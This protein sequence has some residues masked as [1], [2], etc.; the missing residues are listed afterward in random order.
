MPRSE[1]D[2]AAP[3]LGAPNAQTLALVGGFVLAAA[4]TLAVFLTDDAQHL[5]VAVVAV[6][7]AFVL[8]M[9]AAGRRATD[10]VAAAAREAELHRVYEHE[11][12]REVAA[13]REYELELENDLR[14]EA[15]DSMRDEL[16]ALRGDL[17]AL[18]SLRDDVARVAALGD[19]VAQLSAL[20]HDL[21]QLGELRADM[22]RLRAEL[23]EQLSSELFIERIV[24]RTQAG[25]L[26]TDVGR[27][28]VSGHTTEGR[29]SE[30]T[31]TWRDD[32]PPRELT[33]GWPAV[34]LDEPRAT[35]QFEQVRVEQ[36]GVRP[37]V[38]MSGPVS[39]RS[40]DHEPD[41]RSWEIPATASWETLGTY[42]PST[43][44]FP[45]VGQ[46]PGT[47]H[48][49]DARDED[50]TPLGSSAQE[51]ATPIED[52]DRSRHSADAF[53]AHDLRPPPAAPPTA[54]F[55]M[56]APGA[57]RSAAPRL[58]PHK[59]PRPAAAPI[60]PSVVAPEPEPVPSPLEWLAAR[61]L[62][63]PPSVSAR[64]DVPPRR[65][66]DDDGPTDPAEVATTQRPAVPP[67]VRGDDRGGSRAAVGQEQPV[68][69]G[70]EQP[71]EPVEPP[72]QEKRLADILAENGISL[73][74]GGRRRRRYRA[75]DDAD[76]VLARVLRN[77]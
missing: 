59:R 58:T 47:T 52:G 4:A 7:W 69:V 68:A 32:V 71:V 65:R 74:A 27:G 15:G 20:R 31:V 14:R 77:N 35:W 50:A 1:D 56:A 62:L 51:S 57:G 73:G 49:S 67:P 12:A 64:P 26:S 34:R 29:I 39:W 21:G 6:A 70:Q 8:A 54:A 9:F 41:R 24:M 72:R 25:R 76:D 10:R 63:D 5:R 36:T 3:R 33:G 53:R 75:E 30:G 23:A 44:A 17:A 19:D 60:V 28:D 46:E 11:L 42:L 66:R 61:S 40:G 37:P 55:P 16:E 13:R 22:G 48:S 2:D 45:A 43:T 38:P 18:S